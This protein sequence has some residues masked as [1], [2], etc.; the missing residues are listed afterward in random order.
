MP[1]LGVGLHVL[2]A[3]FFAIHAVKSRQ[4]TY[5]L[6]ILFAFPLLGSVV[7]FFA[8]FLPEMRY[9]RMGRTAARALVSI[10]DPARELRLAEKAF[11]L[12]PTVGNRIRLAAAL[13]EAGNPSSALEQYQQAANGPF[14]TDP[15]LLAGMARTWM[16]LGD[17]ARSLESAEKLLAGHP[18]RR[19]Q[20]P[21]ALLYAR[22]LA[23]TNSAETR[24]A[25]DTALT[26]GDGPEVKCRYADWL[27]TRDNADDRDKARALY[28]EVIGDSRYWNTGYSKALNRPWLQ[29]ARQA[30]E[31]TAAPGKTSQ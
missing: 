22:A 25:F 30:L 26:A 3:L 10:V 13:L 16:A 2:I 20:A 21:I 19:Q 27:S 9:S 18:Q 31:S 17:P 28:E 8:I 6:Y 23:E 4:N 12:T 11:E 1:I 24:A 14:A 29:H 15:E 5:W 7:Y